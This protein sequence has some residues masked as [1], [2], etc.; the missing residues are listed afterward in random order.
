[1]K[2]I[3]F[4]ES[5]QKLVDTVITF[6]PSLLGVLLILIVGFWLIRRFD[7]IIKA[8]FT[9]K[10]LDASLIAFLRTF[11]SIVLKIILVVSATGMLGFQTSSFAA[12]LAAAGLA[13]GLAMQGSLSNLAGGILILVLKPFKVGDRITVQGFTGTI[14]EIRIFNTIMVTGEHR[15]VILPNGALSNGN[16]VNESRVGILK[17]NLLVQ[18]LSTENFERVKLILERALLK[19]PYVL[20]EPTPEV[21]IQSF[22]NGTAVLNVSTFCNQNEHSE[23]TYATNLIISREFIENKIEIPMVERQ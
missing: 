1:M 4:Q 11:L 8:S 3:N 23:C 15:T 18:I 7:K 14:K 17:L 20:K 19:C 2:E 6:T 5:F 21:N 16:I 22:V 13:I 10:N 12:I 9:N